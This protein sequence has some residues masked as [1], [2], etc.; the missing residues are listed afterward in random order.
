MFLKGVLMTTVH[1]LGAAV[2]VVAILGAGC[3][4]MTSPRDRIVKREAPAPT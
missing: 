4:T 1:G 2:L 3:T